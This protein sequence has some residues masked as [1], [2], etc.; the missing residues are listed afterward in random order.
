MLPY[1]NHGVSSGHDVAA[2]VFGAE[3]PTHRSLH[4][5]GSGEL[6]RLVDKVS[7]LVG[8]ALGVDALAEGI[9]DSAWAGRVEKGT[10]ECEE[11]DGGQD[12]GGGHEGRAGGVLG[13]HCWSRFE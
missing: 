5:S 1:L 7:G 2:P 9:A 3:G 8:A 13:G 6:V 12:G 11:G 4:V 10:G